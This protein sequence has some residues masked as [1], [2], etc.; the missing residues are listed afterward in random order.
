MANGSS[1]TMALLLGAVA[2][3]L[4]M[5]AQSQ[6]QLVTPT[7]GSLF[8]GGCFTGGSIFSSGA[9]SLERPI[10]HFELPHDMQGDRWDLES[11]L[12]ERVLLHSPF[13]VLLQ[14]LLVESLLRIVLELC[15]SWLRVVL[16]VFPP[17]LG[18][19][20][21]SRGLFDIVHLF[22]IS[23]LLAEK[24]VVWA[25]ASGHLPPCNWRAPCSLLCSV[26]A[27]GIAWA[28]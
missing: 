17:L 27:G 5:Q 24:G 4:Y 10:G 25:V 28:L 6:Q 1:Q 23:V 22:A 21:I 13:V 14:A 8:G 19:K 26:G 9:P 18:F 16:H 2:L 15:S 20:H 3:M 11:G 7:G 12:I